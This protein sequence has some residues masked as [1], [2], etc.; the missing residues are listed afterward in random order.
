MGPDDDSD[1]DELT[2]EERIAEEEAAYWEKH[3]RDELALGEP[4]NVRV[5]R[6]V[7]HV[8]S[9]RID[10]DE[11]DAIA[12]AAEAAGQNVSEFIREAAMREVR[13]RR[14]ASPAVEELKRKAREL[15]EAVE[16]L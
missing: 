16:R 8:Y 1:D 7:K 10:P 2:E 6:N 3:M 12:E 14:S 13:R 4:V 9:F 11:L 5:A 15:A